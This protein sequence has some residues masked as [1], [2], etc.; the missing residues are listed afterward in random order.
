MNCTCSPDSIF[1]KY[2]GDICKKHDVAYATWHDCFWHKCLSDIQLGLSILSRGLKSF[3][4]GVSLMFVAPLYMLAVLIL[5][6]YAWR[7]AHGK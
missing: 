5:G 3:I 6:G 4:Q 1:G 7:K 2:I